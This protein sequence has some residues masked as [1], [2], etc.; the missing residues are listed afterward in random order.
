MTIAIKDLPKNIQKEVELAKK[1]MK[2]SL[3]EIGLSQ[4]T[5]KITQT[6]NVEIR[7]QILEYDIEKMML[8]LSKENPLLHTEVVAGKKEFEEWAK[9]W[10]TKKVKYFVTLN[11][12]G[13]GLLMKH[14]LHMPLNAF[15]QK[16]KQQEKIDLME[17][18]MKKAMTQ[19]KLSVYEIKQLF[20]TDQSK[21][22]QD[23]KSGIEELSRE[24]GKGVKEIEKLISNR[25]AD[26]LAKYRREIKRIMIS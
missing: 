14:N 6:G 2:S 3:A 22:N 11:Y 1:E 9:I 25:V 24:K 16:F 5:T 15:W 8:Y 13:N 10:S 7:S 20:N 4:I 17:K 23:I 18:N 12:G 26:I 21:K 19:Q